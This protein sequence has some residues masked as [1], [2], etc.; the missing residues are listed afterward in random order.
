MLNTIIP[1]VFIV[2]RRGDRILLGR[3]QGT[4]GAGLLCPPGGHVE[5][6]ESFSVAAIREAREEVGI[7]LEA[8]NLI[9]YHVMHRKNAEGQERIDMYFL[10]EVWRGEPVNKEPHK[11]SELIWVSQNEIPA[12]CVAIFTQGFGLALKSIMYSENW[13]V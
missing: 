12:D 11:C 7:E 2:F 9:P 3:R 6:G 4:W 10:V 13:P 8:K 5:A 1:A